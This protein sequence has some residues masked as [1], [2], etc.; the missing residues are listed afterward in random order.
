[1]IKRAECASRR[2]IVAASLSEADAKDLAEGLGYIFCHHNRTPSLQH[3]PRA[4][5]VPDVT[6]VLPARI[7]RRLHKPEEIKPQKSSSARGKYVY[8]N[9]RMGLSGEEMKTLLLVALK[10]RAWT[11]VAASKL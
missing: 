5:P 7:L 11:P 3:R 6:Q 2:S 8:V 4:G 1:M 9:T 10:R